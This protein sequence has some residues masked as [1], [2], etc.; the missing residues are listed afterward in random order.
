LALG[1]G[2]PWRLLTRIHA[3]AARWL[4]SLFAYQ[5]ILEATPLPTVPRLLAKSIRHSEGL[6]SQH[7][8]SFAEIEKA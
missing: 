2:N 5:I 7:A 8:G 4:P 6:Q 1:S 3:A